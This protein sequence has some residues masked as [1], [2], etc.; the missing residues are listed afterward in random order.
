[1]S[2]SPVDLSEPLLRVVFRFDR[3]HAEPGG[4]FAEIA[5]H[6]TAV[7]PSLPCFVG[8]CMRSFP[9]CAFGCRDSIGSLNFIHAAA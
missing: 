1:M 7:G 3:E 9:K 5:A 8:M 4:K 2:P 6:G